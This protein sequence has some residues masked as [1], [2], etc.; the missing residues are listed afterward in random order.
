MK[1]HYPKVTQHDEAYDIETG[2]TVERRIYTFNT[3]CGKS[4]YNPVLM[5]TQTDR[6]DCGSCLR[7]IEACRPTDRR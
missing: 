7:I 5:T 1:T 3:Q 6:V 4:L 2:K